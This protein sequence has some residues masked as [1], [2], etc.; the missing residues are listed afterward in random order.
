MIYGL[1][2][3]CIHIQMLDIHAD[4]HTRSGGKHTDTDTL[5]DT[6]Y[7]SINTHAST[8]AHIPSG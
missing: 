4:K 3:C 5:T 7:I 8:Y 6:V 1:C 2:V